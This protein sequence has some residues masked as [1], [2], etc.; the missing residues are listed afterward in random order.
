MS[1]TP[2]VAI[3]ILN[4]NGK[5]YLNLNLPHLYRQ[6][7]ENTSLV[8]IDNA[9]TDDSVAWLQQKHPKIRLIQN[10][11]NYG[12]AKGYNIGLQHV[13]SDYYLLLNTD[14]EVTRPFLEPMVALLEREERASVCQPK[15]RSLH[16]RNRF[17]YAGAAGGLIDALGYPF[18]R[19]RLFFHCEEDTGQY[20]DEQEIF[21]AGGACFLIK[22]SCFWELNGFYEFYFMQHEETDLCWRLKQKGYK[23]MYTGKSVVYHEGGAHLEYANPQKNYLNFRNNWVMLYRNLPRAYFWFYIVPQRTALDVAA[24]F[25]F[26]FQ[27]N[28]ETFLSVYKALSGFWKWW[29]LNRK[30][31]RTVLSSFRSLTGV[32]NGWI[33]VDY[34]IKRKKVL[35]QP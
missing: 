29:W 19:G 35:P 10:K 31:K 3:V 23:I 30:K 15:I 33:V 22:R 14:V 25:Y 7:Y 2:S 17:E 32:Y 20:D 26:L 1:F 8:V 4:F 21:W 34:F 9:S 12:F 18:A 11:A 16:T 24:S 13:E 5:E 27:N 28:V 6:S